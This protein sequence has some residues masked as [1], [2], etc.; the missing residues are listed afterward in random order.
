MCW[1]VKGGRLDTQLLKSKLSMLTQDIF[2]GLECKGSLDTMQVDCINISWVYSDFRTIIVDTT[3]S[4][5]MDH[6]IPFVLQ[7]PIC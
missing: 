1:P 5:L 7:V 4:Q 3:K 2:L 6:L